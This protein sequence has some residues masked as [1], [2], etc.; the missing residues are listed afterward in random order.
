MLHKRVSLW[1]QLVSPSKLC[2]TLLVCTARKYTQLLCFMLCT[3]HQSDH[4]KSAG[5]KAAGRL[6]MNIDEGSIYNH[7]LT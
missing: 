1:Q 5:A 3:V 2:P 4:R 6:M 7:L